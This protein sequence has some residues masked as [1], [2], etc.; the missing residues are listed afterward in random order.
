MRIQ[1]IPFNPVAEGGFLPKYLMNIS[2]ARFERVGVVL[3]LFLGIHNGMVLI[4]KRGRVLIIFLGS[5]HL[6]LVEVVV[7]KTSLVGVIIRGRGFLLLEVH[8]FY[9]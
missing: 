8:F 9:Y 1:F 7:V 4:R 3:L 2:M 6:S 5:L